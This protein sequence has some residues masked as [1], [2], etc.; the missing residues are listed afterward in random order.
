MLPIEAVPEIWETSL[1]KVEFPA[2]YKLGAVHGG[3]AQ[4]VFGSETFWAYGIGT[5]R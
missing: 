1:C 3:V 5:I 4:A 2:K